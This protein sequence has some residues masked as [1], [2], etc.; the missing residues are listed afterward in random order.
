MADTLGKINPLR[1][2]GYI[3]DAET[4]LYYLQS[5]YYDPQVGRFLNADALVSTGEGLLGNNMFAYCL[6]N[7]TNRIDIAGF[8]SQEC[9]ND[10]PNNDDDPLNDL[11][12]TG[13]S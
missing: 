11:G 13:H 2:R 4:E 7:P 8:L 6:N 3:Y 1:Y 12:H 10:D 9:K 5:R